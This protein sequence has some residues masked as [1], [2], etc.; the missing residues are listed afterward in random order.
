MR[1]TLPVTG[2]AEGVAKGAF[3]QGQAFKQRMICNDVPLTRLQSDAALKRFI[4]GLSAIVW[5][6]AESFLGTVI[7]I[8]ATADKQR[9]LAHVFVCNHYV[10]A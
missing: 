4:I 6:Q 5:F 8:I 9:S 2:K 3:S 1:R 7:Y 10:K